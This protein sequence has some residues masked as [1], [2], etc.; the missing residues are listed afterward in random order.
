M[1]LKLFGFVVGFVVMAGLEIGLLAALHSMPRGL[2]WIALPVM[3]GVGL[4]RA[5]PGLTQKA[6]A[7]G[8]SLWRMSSG[9]R[10]VGTM[11]AVWLVAVPAFWW[12]FKPYDGYRMYANDYSLMF[13]VML[14]PIAVVIASYVA[15]AKLVVSSPTSSD[16]GQ[17]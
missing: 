16:E 5:T 12:L 3:A 8:T 10:L 2:G 7:S 9:V 15:Y 6:L 11:S 17:K 14:F 13:K 1:V 4:A